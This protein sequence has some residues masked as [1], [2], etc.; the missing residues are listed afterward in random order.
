MPDKKSSNEKTTKSSRSLIAPWFDFRR[1]RFWIWVAVLVYTLAGFVLAPVL[2]SH[3]TIKN[4][5][6]STDREASIAEVRVNPYVLSLEVNGFELKDT[7]GEPLFSFDQFF[8]NFQAS[9][10]FRWALTFREIRLDGMY[11]F[12]ERFSSGD[13]RLARLLTDIERLNPETETEESSGD[14]PR[15]LVSELAFNEGRLLFRDHAPGETVEIPAGPIS[16]SVQNL[17]TLPD[18]DGNQQVQVKLNRGATLTWQGDLSLQPL[19]SEGEFTLDGSELDPLD[20]YFKAILPLESIQARLSAHTNYLLSEEADASLSLTLSDMEARL[21]NVAISG[22]EP[23]SEFLAFESLE[24]NGGVMKYPA[25]TVRFDSVRLNRPFVDVWLGEDGQ[26]GLAQLAP[27]ED[28]GAAADE[29]TEPWDIRLGEFSISGGRMALADRSVQP[30]AGVEIQ[31]L[32]LTLSG[33]DNQEGTQMPLSVALGLSAGGTFG[34]EG[35]VV[36]LPDVSLK[37]TATTADIPVSLVQPYVE[38]HLA[39]AIESGLLRSSTEVSLDPGGAVRA[40]GTLGTSGLK[41]GDTR[42]NE[43]LLA[44]NDMAIDRFE[45]DTST[46]SARVSSIRF[47]EPYGRFQIK[48]DLSTNVGNV[49]LE[50]PES[51]APATEDESWT[52]VIGGI[53]VDKGSMYFSDL[54]LF[55]PFATRIGDL[56]GTIST[57]DNQSSE[58][59]NIRLEGQVDDYGLSRIEGSMNL[60]DPIAKTDVSVEFRNLEMTDLSPYSAEFAGREIDQGKL[61][62]DLL[63]VIDGG[64]LAGQNAVVLSDLLLGDL[65]LIHI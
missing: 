51:G 13:D 19:R 55:L 16:V 22:L 6:E 52:A 48:E 46:L 29:P 21:E 26:P 40:V 33:I 27:A 18:I 23:A 65:S 62:L 8:V 34:F 38:Q 36:A 49:M 44:W 47:T 42:E 3:F 4:I 60:L 31:G 32:E 54:S 45:V 64:Q 25:Q 39:V 41:V 1:K 7:D 15:L 37:G 63:Y 17:N 57:I 5:K 56:N 10:L 58:P 11:A 53:A 30:N 24:V 2:V 43:S 35:E 28:P 61:D 20:P 9:S 59:S 50:S 12:Y 14:L